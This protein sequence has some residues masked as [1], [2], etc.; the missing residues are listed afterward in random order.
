MFWS[1]GKEKAQKAIA[2]LISL[3]KLYCQAFQLTSGHCFL[4][5]PWA[6]IR[7]HLWITL[8][9]IQHQSRYIFPSI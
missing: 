3:L 1:V 7:L 9:T 4:L 6:M 5:D 8:L 2:Y